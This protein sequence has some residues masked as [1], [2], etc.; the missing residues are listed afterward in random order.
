M[1]NSK[2]KLSKNLF[3]KKVDLEKPRD[4]YGKG[5]VELGK[6]DENV[7]V[8]CCDLT[9][10]T[11]SHWFK[12]EFPERFVEV[13]VAEQNM[14]GIA[15][16]MASVGKKPFC[17]SYAVF[18]PGRNWDQIRVSV[19]YSNLNVIIA[20]AHA[21]ISVGPDGATHQALEDIA[22]S[23]VLPNMTVVVPADMQEALRATVALGKIKG[24]GY[25]RFGREGVP[26]ITTEKT[27]FKIGKAEL[28]WDSRSPVVAI[29]TCGPL[30]YEALIAAKELEK[31]GIQVLVVNNHTVKP[32]D[33]QTLVSVARRTGAV[34]TAEEHQIHGGMGSAVAE[35][36][37]KN[38]PVPMEFVGMQDSFGESGDPE[39]LLEKYHMKS[40]DILKAVKKVIAKKNQ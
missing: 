39:E 18:N 35:V 26:S 10:S 23:R 28:L 24:P 6:K 14:A 32:I 31:S 30:V 2:L 36:L 17:S 20:G 3:T 19:C 21:G 15:A 25:I 37:V 7:V 34:V 5:L 40:E 8:L 1:I 12:E 11:R 38:H 4:G 33:E 27:P 13:G 22:I 29:V 16:G 9:E